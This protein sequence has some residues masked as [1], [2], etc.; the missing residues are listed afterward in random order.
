MTLAI[1]GASCDRTTGRPLDR[2]LTGVTWTL[3]SLLGH[4]PLPLG[5]YLDATFQNGAVRG[6]AG[7]NSFGGPYTAT[8]DGAFNITELSSTAVGCSDPVIAREDAYL[9]ALGR[10]SAYD[11]VGDSLTLKA[12]GVDVAVFQ[13]NAPPPITGLKWHAFGY[14]DGPVDDQQAIVAPVP[15]STSTTA[16]GADGTITGSGGCNSYSA[17][18]STTRHQ[19]TI[20]AITKGDIVCA[21]KLAGQESAYL[22]ALAATGSWHFS[23]PS[24]QLLN[25]S[26]TVEVTFGPNF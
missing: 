18:Y 24:F 13:A 9:S 20:T 16:C 1:L 2:Q 4:D 21:R 8:A 15:G 3:T 10:A 23:G 17:R 5:S 6:S 7:C 12:G 19:M 11:I 14:R 25:D 22:K 26:G